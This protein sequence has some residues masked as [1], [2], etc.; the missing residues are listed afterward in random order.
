MT[1][2]ISRVLRCSLVGSWGIHVWCLRLAETACGR[3]P[4]CRSVDR[5]PLSGASCV[6]PIVVPGSAVS[7]EKRTTASK[8]DAVVSFKSFSNR[9][10]SFPVEAPGI[11]PGSEN[12]STTATTCV[13]RP[14]MFPRAGWQTTHSRMSPLYFAGTPKANAP[15]S[16][17]LRY[18]QSR[19]G[20]ASSWA[21]AGVTKSYA[22]RAKLLFA[23]GI[24]SSVLSGARRPEHAATASLTPSKPVA[25]VRCNLVDARPDATLRP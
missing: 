23:V 3:S 7:A 10:Q 2:P 1:R 15:A 5:R 16:P 12:R 9:S 8:A 14:W 22:A 21:L 4:T 20:R 25:P 18:P 11:E 19:P 17:D 24:L 13:V 6:P